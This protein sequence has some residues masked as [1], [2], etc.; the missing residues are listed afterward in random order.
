[1][2]TTRPC[3]R[4]GHAMPAEAK[5]CGQCG[6]LSEPGPKTEP[7]PPPEASGRGLS[8][9]VL[10]FHPPAPTSQGPGS[11]SATLA[12]NTDVD[13][14][15]IVAAATN[16][17]VV[18]PAS[19]PEARRL[20]TAKS[21]MIGMSAADLY[22]GVTPTLPDPP[23]QSPA[24][25][26]APAPRLASQTMLGVARPGIAPTQ[27][28]ADA[29]QPLPSKH[30]TMLGVAQP[31]IAP[32][33]PRARPLAPAPVAAPRPPPVDIVPAPAPLVDDEPAPAVPVVGVKKGVPL[34]LVAAIVGGVIVFGGGLAALLLWRGAPA[35]TGS[36]GLDAKGNDVLHLHCEACADGTKVSLNNATATFTKHET[37][38]ALG[39]P[40]HV[41]SNP[42]A[43]HIDRP[44]SGRDE[45][46]SLTVPVDYRV[47][48]DL[49]T[50]DA[51]SPVI[52]VR[53]EALAG[54]TVQIDGKPVALDAAGKG[55]YAIDLG[56]ATLGPGDEQ[57]VHKEAPYVVTT[58][59]GIARKGS[60]SAD[61]TVLP[62]SID[63]PGVASVVDSVT[64]IVVGRI[65]KSAQVTVNGVVVQTTPDGVF[66]QTVAAPAVGDVPVEVR[67]SSPSYAPRIA[68]LSVKR[69]DSLG[70]WAKTIDASPPPGFDAIAPQSTS[71]VGEPFVVEGEVADTSVEAKVQRSV[72]VIDDRR[73]CAKGPCLTRVRL[74]RSDPGAKRGDVLRIYGHVASPFATKDGS[75]VLT[76]DGD[77]VV[78]VKK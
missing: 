11:L 25:A 61:V 3:P 23:T 72:V 44:G 36:A 6:G 55:A 17:T 77:Y 15:K 62:L 58:K 53:V 76:V 74:A 31:G 35:L 48:P 56:P 13:V 67:T 41:G 22:R 68:K 57:H 1:M 40:L 26:P 14:A 8:R 71:H 18:D 33:D 24:A 46:V 21:T 9:T 45:T 59:G 42:L 37:D 32:V 2:A 43:L 70:A 7:A 54:S 4:C 38:L 10:E 51:P 27:A 60:V 66:T 47:F 63:R 52:T 5:F 29:P 12:S 64:F 78:T 69:V 50:I 73:G 28:S 30:Q 39:V 65:Y 16:V 34:A 20:A 19:R 49:T 75:S